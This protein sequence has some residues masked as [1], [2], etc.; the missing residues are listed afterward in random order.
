MNSS[1]S[2]NQIDKPL[3]R[4][5]FARSLDTYNEAACV[6]RE[7]AHELLRTLVEATQ[8]R[9]LYPRIVEAGCGTGILTEC[10]EKA[11]EYEELRLIDIVPECGRFHLK[12]K[13]AAFIA[14]DVENVELPGQNDLF[15]ANAVFQ[16]AEHQQALLNKIKRSLNAGGVLAFTTFGPENLREIGELTGGRLHYATM[17]EWRNMLQ[18]AGF[19]ILK[20]YEKRQTMLFET[21]LDIL[22]HLKAT[23]VTGTGTKTA[24]NRAKIQEFSRQYQA[25]H[26]GGDGRVAVT[27]HAIFAVAEV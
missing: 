22:R 8:G 14:G 11:L 21:P 16:W 18:K 13:K 17:D 12:R 25:M 7:M 4:Q 5:R 15:A 19:T 3:V 6:Q 27:Y 2:E 23:G 26:G 1:P 10:M 24:W 20:L 9:R